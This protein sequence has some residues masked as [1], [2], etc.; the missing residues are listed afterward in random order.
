MVGVENGVVFIQNDASKGI[1]PCSPSKIALSD[2]VA[3]RSN[4]MLLP[5]KGFDTDSGGR[6]AKEMARIESLVPK[7]LQG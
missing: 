3:M 1:I 7:G 4:G 6:L 2:V 5:T